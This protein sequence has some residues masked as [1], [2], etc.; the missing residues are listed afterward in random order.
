MIALGPTLPLIVVWLVIRRPLARERRAIGRALDAGD[1]GSRRTWPCEPRPASL[2]AHRS[3]RTADPW[4]DLQVGR[5]A[6]LASMELARLGLTRRAARASLPPGVKHLDQPQRSESRNARNLRSV[7]S[8]SRAGSEPAT[9]P[10][11]A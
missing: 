8:T 10:A 1:D 7:S 2:H 4:G 3:G 5:H 6:G 9:M 11:P